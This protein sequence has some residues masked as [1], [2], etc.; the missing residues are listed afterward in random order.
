MFED[1]V[2]GLDEG[3]AVAEEAMA[4]LGG[5]V[6]DAAWDGEDFAVLF[7]GK[8]GGDEGAATGSG[9]DNDCADR[10][11]ADDAIALG[12]ASGT[13]RGVGR[14]FAEEGPAL[15]DLFG[16]GVV[17]GRVDVEDAATED[18]EG[19]SAGG[20]GAAV[21]SGIDTA[22]QAA[23]DGDAGSCEAPG[24]AFRLA[25][26]V[27]SCVACADDGNSQAVCGA[28]AAAEEKE[29]GRI[30]DLFEG[31]WIGVVVVGNDADVVF[32]AEIE[33]GVDVDVA[34]GE[35]DGSGEFGADTGDF[36]ELVHGGGEDAFRRVESS[37]EGLANSGPHARDHG[38]KQVVFQLWGVHSGFR[39]QGSGFG[40][41]MEQW[42]NQDM[43]G[44]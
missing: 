27:V 4:A 19:S 31:G 20:E 13:R 11:A 6:V 5:A 24:K 17:F 3:G 12:E 18:G 37:Q 34:L 42:S 8:A 44:V 22:S 23:D 26:S 29:T 35:G 43:G 16:E 25:E 41:A 10:E 36:A 28:E 2:D 38:E 15:E 21:G 32:A 39:V 9:F 33:L 7:G 40:G 1:V 30:V 14:S